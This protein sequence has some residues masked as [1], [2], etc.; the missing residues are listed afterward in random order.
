VLVLSGV[1]ALLAAL[2]GERLFNSSSLVWPLLVFM[3][4]AGSAALGLQ[5]GILAGRGRFYATAVAIAAE[6]LVRLVAGIAVV[7][8]AD[9]VELFAATLALGVV[10]IVFWPEAWR[11]SGSRASS[12]TESVLGFLGGLAG[13]ILIAQVVLNVGPAVLK[14]MGGDDADVTGL[15]VSLALFRAP[16]LLALGLATRITGPLT[17]L[18]VDRRFREI[19]LLVYATAGVT[20][21]G[22]VAGAA[23]GAIAGPWAIDLVFDQGV[24]PD[25]GVV[26]GIAAGSVVALGGLMLILVL[27]ATGRTPAVSI[28]WSIGLVAGGLVLAFTTGDPLTRVVAAFIMAEI[29][30]FSAMTAVLLIWGHRAERDAA[31]AGGEVSH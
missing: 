9:S 15:F 6:N 12:S 11:F 10:V 30:A 29:V 28:A 5:R 8:A 31:A 14:A 4:T 18:V 7:V 25:S 1:L 22:A 20:A 24:A 13:G 19:R 17:G 16:Y 2:G 26:A 27:L 21:V 3:V 23:F